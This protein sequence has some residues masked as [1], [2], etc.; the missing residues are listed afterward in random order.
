MKQFLKIV[1]VFGC[2]VWLLA[3]CADYAISKGLQHSHDRKFVVWNDIYHKSLNADLLV[4]GSSRAWTGYN[5]YILDSM[6]HV[7]SYNLGID[8]Q[9]IYYQILRYHTYR[10]FNQRP[11]VILLNVDYYS[12]FSST[13]E[14]QYEREQY[15]PYFYDWEL[16]RQVKDD[17]EFTILDRFCPLCRYIG[18]R[19]C[20]EMGI[21][22]FFGVEE[23][24]GK[25]FYKGFQG[26]EIPWNSQPLWDKVR[27]LKI[28]LR[29]YEVLVD[30]IEEV[31]RE[32]IK[33]L[34]ARQP[35]Y[36]GT[37]KYFNN[38]QDIERVFEE[39]SERHDVPIVGEYETEMSGS[40]EYFY[41]HS[42][43]NKK[44]AER[45]TIELCKKVIDRI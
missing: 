8:G 38:V 1:S 3:L 21:K 42:H 45:F 44:G 20:F 6:L 28:E 14:K 12:T 37:D 29:E 34:M 31:K 9:S 13:S 23:S 18:Y 35:F 16:I 22:T 33:L 25:D 19:Y 10:R 15:F 4:L 41:N 7:N 24:V 26:Q 39:L 40:T 27:D 5:T 36:T 2:L 11:D 17:K 43:L 30:F 32:N